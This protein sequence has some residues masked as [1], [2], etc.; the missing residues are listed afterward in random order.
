MQRFTDWC[1]EPKPP[2]W[3]LALYAVFVITAWGL[4]ANNDYKDQREQECL[5]RSTVK[6]N[7]TYDSVNDVC[8]KEKRNGTTNQNR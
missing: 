3:L 7:V 2:R 1:P 5:N 8:K 6:W 4:L